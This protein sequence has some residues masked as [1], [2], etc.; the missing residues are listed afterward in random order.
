MRFPFAFAL[1]GYC[2]CFQSPWNSWMVENNADNSNLHPP[3]RASQVQVIKSSEKGGRDKNKNCLEATGSFEF[4][5]AQ[6]WNFNSW[7]NR[8]LSTCSP[9][10]GYKDIEVRVLGRI[11]ENWFVTVAVLLRK[12]CHFYYLFQSNEYR[13]MHNPW[14]FWIDRAFDY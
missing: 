7:K 11:R 14:Q 2:F 8:A 12:C 10:L 6:T 1:V 4:M 13:S 3:H 5:N 9:N